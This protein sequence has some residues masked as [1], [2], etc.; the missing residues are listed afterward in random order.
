MPQICLSIC[1][2]AIFL[3]SCPARSNEII[4]SPSGGDYASIQQALNAAHAGDIVTV[5][6]GTYPEALVFP[7]SGS[8]IS[9]YI[10]LRAGTGAT[11]TVDPNADTDAILIENRSYL[12]ISGIEVTNSHGVSD[13]AGIRVR[14]WGDRIEIRNNRM[15]GLTGS[16]AVGIMILGNSA[17]PISRVVIDGNYIHDC[18]PAQSEALVLNGNVTGF[19]VTNNTV[20]DVNNIGIDFIGG[21]SWTGNY[22]VAREGVCR[23][24]HVYRA[25]SNYGGGYAAGIYVDGGREI[26]VEGNSVHECDLGIEIGAENSGYTVTGVIVRNNI[27][28][29]NDKA[30]IVFGGYE[31]ARGRVNDC[32]FTGNTLYKNDTLK[33]GNGEFAVNWAEGNRIRNNVVWAGPQNLLIHAESGSV[34]NVFDN[35]LYYA[36]AGPSAAEVDWRG[37]LYTGF[38]NYRAKTSQDAASFFTDPLLEDPDGD[39]FHL[40]FGSAAINAGDL[41]DPDL[42]GEYDYYGNPRLDGRTVDIGADEYNALARPDSG[43][44]DGDGTADIAVFRGYS[45]LWA[46]R[47]VTRAYFG[48]GGDVPV[49]GVYGAGRAAEMGIYRPAVGLW[50]IRGTTRIYF[51]AS[52]DTPVPGDYDGDDRCEAAVFRSRTGLWAV[53]GVTRVYF[54]SPAD[55][56]VPG[57]YDGDGTADIAVFRRTSGL[58]AIRK[59]TRAY[60]GSNSDIPVPGDYSGDGIRTPAIFRPA[61]GLWA[62]RGTTRAYFGVAADQPVPADYDGDG[63]DDAGIFRDTTA[64]WAVHDLFRVYFGRGGDVPVTR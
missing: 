60:F 4:V 10:T 63:E 30:G 1:F 58:W 43:D 20:H 49:P 26:V 19:E 3:L 50:A 45:G 40:R 53:R 13:G 64:L 5:L 47:G 7:R 41:S 2:P 46:V 17:T 15:Y 18:E 31:E 42:L 59:V 29:D 35:N 34:D 33:D 14:G 12:K 6:T 38:E 44:Y 48:A 24:N 55:L 51:G 39:D 21:E 23:G 54:A 22:G 8:E 62:V 36:P 27:V 11:V 56:P 25:R 32:E 61:A 52:G 28:Y 16:D 37:T 57:D 9:G